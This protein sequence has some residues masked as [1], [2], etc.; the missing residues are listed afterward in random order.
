MIKRLSRFTTASAAMPLVWAGAAMAQTTP[1]ASA[2]NEDTL[3]R[4]LQTGE[5]IGGRVSIP[6][7]EAAALITPDNRLWANMHSGVLP[8]VFI[9]A[10]L[11]TLAVLVLFYLIRGR[12]RIEGG[13]SGRK[14]L[15]FN[16]VERF[17]HWL[18]A[19]T[20]IILALTGLNLILG[21]TVILPLLGEN[22]FGTITAWGKVAHNYLAWPFMLGLVMVFLLWVIH[23]IPSKI[24]L[25]WIRKGGGLLKRGVHVP[26]RKFNFGQKLV[27]WA[28]VIGGA[29]MSATGIMLLFPAEAGSAADWQFY[30]LVHAIVAAAMSALI[31][32]HIYIG[33]LG[34]E[35][36]F[37][38]MG[39]G[40]V[41]ENWAREH[42]SLWVDE[43]KATQARNDARA[44]PAE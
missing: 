21:R 12:I 2:V 16:M 17:A 15:R 6:N 5:S 36:A 9:I 29:I 25:E 28:V 38:A 18:V 20:F 30:Q 37:D 44:T 27:F 42:H 41:D 4:A 43:V 40:E 19:T 3:L 32:G 14:I 1:T 33:T 34:M 11:A 26:A 24:D 22:A 8:V 13:F 31:L 10:I 7:A 39:N 35:G 23:N